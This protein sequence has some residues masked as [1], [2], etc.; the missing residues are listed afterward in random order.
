MRWCP[1]TSRASAAS[2][3][4]SPRSSR[5]WQAPPE[6]SP[7][8]AFLAP[9]DSLLWDTGLLASLFGFEFVW[10][11]YFPPA[12]RRWGYY[13]LP[14]LFGDRL[15]GRIEPRIDR[16]AGRV[17]VLGAWWQDGFAPAGTPGFVEAMREALRAYLRFAGVDRV[18]WAPH[19]TTEKRLLAAPREPQRTVT[20][21]GWSGSPVRAAGSIGVRAAWQRGHH[22]VTRSWVSGPCS[23]SRIGRAAAAAGPAPAAGDPVVLAAAQAAGGALLGVLAVGQHERAG[24]LDERR[25]G[26]GRRRPA[27]T[28]A[29]RR[30][31]A[32]RPCRG[33]RSRPGCAGR[34]GRRRSARRGARGAGA[35]PRRGPSPGRGRRGRGGRRAGPPPP[36]A[37]A[38]RSCSR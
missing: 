25:P 21:R 23:P 12:K 18:E 19:L 11:G 38:A 35:A 1:S 3:W 8:V 4:S 10:E 26:R 29:R 34:A 2:A 37:R 6:P 9:Y 28:G 14:I 7:S 22:Q 30:G 20:G 5:C 17:Q 32:T 31:T 15:V 27:P 13:V 16:D 33:C 36:S 24:A